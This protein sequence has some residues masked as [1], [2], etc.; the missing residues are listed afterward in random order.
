MT[1]LNK[2]YRPTWYQDAFRWFYSFILVL[3]I[4]FAFINL[5]LR[6]STR[7]KDYNRR[8]FERFGFVAHAPKQQGYLFHCVSVGEV[9]AASCLIK[10]IMQEQPDV[11]ITVTTTTPT[12]SARVRAIFGDAVHHFYLPYDLHMAMAGMLKRIK[13]S[14]VMITEVELWPNLIHACWKR[15]IPVVVINARMTDRS[16]RRYK[17]FPALFEPMLHKLSHVCAQGERDFNNYQFLGMAGDKLTL[18]QNIKFD[19]AAALTSSKANFLE[20]E[21]QKRQILIG[22]STHDPEESV[23]LDAYRELK[24][25]YPKLLLILVPRHP[26]RFELVAKMVVKSG[27]QLLRSADSPT[28]NAQCDVV[29][30]NEMGRL[31]AAYDVADIAFVGGSIAERGGH[32]ALEPA[33]KKLPILMGMSTHNNPE[34]CSK[35]VEAGALTLIEDGFGLQAKIKHWLDDPESAHRAGMAGFHELVRNSGALDKTLNVVNSLQR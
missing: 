8:R 24:T 21:Q 23:L 20:L 3:V 15:N 4:P 2:P 28:I 11:Q 22:G 1:E 35:L 33:A 32:N 34:I 27:L 30:V 5:V 9:V 13:P 17:K 19:Q 25:Q 6:G 10:R 29:L 14:M 26:E 12:G 31:N 7:S 16:A 18:T